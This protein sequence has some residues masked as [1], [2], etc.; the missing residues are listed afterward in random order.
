[1]VTAVSYAQSP[2]PIENDQSGQIAGYFDAAGTKRFV[3][4][5][6]A[7]NLVTVYFRGTNAQDNVPFVSGA[8]FAVD[9]GPNMEW[10]ADVHQYG[11]WIG[12]TPEVRSGMPSGYSVGFG[13]NVQFGES[14]PI[15][16]AVCI[17]VTSD[18][19]GG[20]NVDGPVVVEHSL[21][22]EECPI[23]SRFPSQDVFDM[24]GARSQTCQLVEMDI[25]PGS[26]RNPFNINVFEWLRGNPNKGGVLP[27]AILG[28]E[29][30]DVNDID[31]ATVLLEGVVPLH[32]SYEDVATLDGHGG[33]ECNDGDADGYMDMTLKFSKL[34]VARALT[35]RTPYDVGQYITLTMTGEYWDG[36]PFSATDCITFVGNEKEKDGPDTPNI[37]DV[38]VLG[39]PTPNPFN[40]VTRVSYSVP[41]TQHVRIAIYDAAG[42]LVENLVNETKGAGEYVVE[43]DAG[44]LPSGVY[45][46]RM[47]TGGQTLVRRAT[48][49]K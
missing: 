43:W 29:T 19:S 12:A 35:A 39:F 1:M 3:D 34:S 31:P 20:Q 46:Y 28:S 13:Y 24:F 5:G 23:I 25:K 11:A 48:L 41:T 42:R 8:Q 22:P 33:C 16:M 27:V 21:F 37:G 2:C 40:P 9:Y 26:C 10:L 6:P 17:W 30:V 49:L 47:Q 38:S 36:M 15:V 45:F 4:P 32:H 14:F 18:C 7:G 44:R